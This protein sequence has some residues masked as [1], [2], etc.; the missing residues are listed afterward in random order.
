MRGISTSSVSTSGLRR[1]IFSHAAYGS[2]DYEAMRHHA[3]EALHWATESTHH[4]AAAIAAGI[5]SQGLA[6][7]EPLEAARLISLM[8]DH[9]ARYDSTDLVVADNL[10]DGPL[11]ARDGAWAIETGNLIA[12]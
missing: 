10:T 8:A 2:G 12:D 9:T 7:P 6:I 3:T 5:M 4:A 11:Q 1:G